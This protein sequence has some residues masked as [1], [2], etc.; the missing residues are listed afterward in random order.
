MT[1][2]DL[3]ATGLRAPQLGFGCATLMGRVGRNGS[4]RALAV[5]W[6]AGVRLFDTARA[7]GYGESEVV[8]GEFLRE[9]RQQAVI[10]TKFGILAAPQPPWKRLA[11]AAARTALKV[12]PSLHSVLQKG[13]GTQFAANQFN[14]AVLHK[15]VEQSLKALRTDTI[16]I[17]YLHSAPAGTLDNDELLAAMAHLVAQGKVRVAGLSATTEVVDAALTRNDARLRAMQFPCN[18]FDL[19]AAGRFQTIA[20]SGQI[21]IANHPFGGAVRVTQCLDRLQHLAIN[22][23][24][25]SELREK[26]KE[27]D[28]SLMPDVVLNSILVGTGIHAVIPAMMNA[29]HIRLNARVVEK[30][31]FTTTEIAAIRKALSIA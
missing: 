4:L 27:E 16:D 10:A 19:T 15:S 3:G 17:L 7:Y 12:A 26:L 21:L 8:L 25:D 18:V 28:P 22:S 20:A 6:D 13:A 9:R 5:A 2:I 23:S 31:R 11:R 29:A 24:L 30:S 1:E 14:I